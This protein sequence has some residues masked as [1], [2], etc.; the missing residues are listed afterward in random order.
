MPA[1]IELRIKGGKVNIEVSDVE[2]ATCEQITKA[3]E[4]LGE[5]EEVQRKPEYYVELEGMEQKIYEDEE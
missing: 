5:V 1:T 2:D 4:E 3:L